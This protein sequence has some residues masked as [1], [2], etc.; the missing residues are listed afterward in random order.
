MGQGDRGGGDAIPSHPNFRNHSR[1]KKTPADTD[2]KWRQPDT[3]STSEPMFQWV[4]HLIERIPRSLITGTKLILAIIGALIAA[5]NSSMLGVAVW[6]AMVAGAVAGQI[7]PAVLF[8]LVKLTL[9]FW[10]DSTGS[11]LLLHCSFYDRL[12][13]RYPGYVNHF[14]L[15]LSLK[16]EY[17]IAHSTYIGLR[18]TLVRI[19]LFL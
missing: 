11:R 8:I 17:L 10:S 16:V 6:V 7:V 1:P 13:L 14:G 15:Q 3:K 9:F 2:A 4:D 19:F 5:A 12:T 18:S